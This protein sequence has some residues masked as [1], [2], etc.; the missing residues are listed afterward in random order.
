MNQASKSLARN[1]G[2]LLLW[3]GQFVSQ[4]GDRLAMVAF[5]WLVYSSTGSALGTGAVFALYTLP[6]VLFG[7]FAGVVID[8][9]NKRAVMIAADIVRGGLVLLVPFAATRSLAAVYVL[10][11]VVASASVFFDPCK[12]AILPDL[13]AK[14]RLMRANSLLAVGENLTE[15]VGYALAGFIL[16]YVSTATAFRIDAVTFAVSAAALMLMRYQ[17]PVRAAAEHAA[18]SFWR[19]LR[20]G[21]S[22]L[23][24]HH[25]LLMNTLMVVAFVA[26]LGASYPLTFLLAVNVLDAGTQAFGVFEAVIGIGYLVGSLALATLATRIPKG[27]AMA[28]GWTAMGVSLVLVAV[29]TGVWQACIPFAVLGLA[30]AVALIALDTWLQDVI[31]ENL[32]GRVFGARFTLTQ[33]TYALSVLVGGALAGVFDV[34]ALLIVAG[35]LMAIPGIAALF[36]R[37]IRNA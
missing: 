27:L 31:P 10:S 5:P 3:V 28:V 18:S 11:F 34:R 21:L 1:S 25:A 19:E 23:R 26:G 12:L 15:I 37:D 16:A 36:V 14:D 24:H 2:F 22:F 29:T 30:N 9:F 13:V 7:A 20:E 35:V 6:Y 4:M 33:G 32:R 8:R 17:A